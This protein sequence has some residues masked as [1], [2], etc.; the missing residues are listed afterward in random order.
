MEAVDGLIDMGID[1]LQALQF[2]ARGMDP[3]ELKR[4]SGDRLCFEGGVS[5]QTT[6]VPA[7]WLLFVV[8]VLGRAPSRL[9]CTAFIN[10]A[11]AAPACLA[12]SPCQRT[13]LRL[14]YD[15]PLIISS[16]AP[17]VRYAPR[18]TCACLLCQSVL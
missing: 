9:S 2:S 11:S 13:R 1:A 5:V 16:L 3:R 8:R 4:R 12:Y 18:R 15:L 17:K 7:V 10:R 14:I 6:L